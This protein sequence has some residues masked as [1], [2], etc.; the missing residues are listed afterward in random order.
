MRRPPLLQSTTSGSIVA[1]A[2]VLLACGVGQG[3]ADPAAADAAGEASLG[4]VG[5]P[6]NIDE[7]CTGDLICA[8]ECEDWCD[9]TVWPNPCC[10][11]GCAPTNAPWACEPAGGVAVA[12]GEGCP[13]EYVL[14]TVPEDWVT[15]PATMQCCLPEHP[16]G[17]I[18]NRTICEAMPHC[19]WLLS[20]EVRTT[21]NDGSCA[22]Q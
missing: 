10:T 15:T 2:L 21:A 13:A 14:P 4:E 22:L 5:D 3:P 8:D 18:G 20:G 9:Q 17:E 7:D 12:D 1:V 16:C 19:A 11:R 6:C